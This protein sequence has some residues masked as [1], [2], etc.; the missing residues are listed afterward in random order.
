MDLYPKALLCQLLQSCSNAIALTA[1]SI[2]EGE[3]Q[4]VMKGDEIIFL[5]VG[6]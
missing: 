5:S 6:L 3:D 1:A 4:S 2:T